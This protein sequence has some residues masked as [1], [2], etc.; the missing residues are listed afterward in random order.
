MLNKIL[1]Q[2][3]LVTESL[4]VASVAKTLKSLHKITDDRKMLSTLRDIQHKI[5]TTTVNKVKAVKLSKR[6][7]ELA[8]TILAGDDSET[9]VRDIEKELK[10]L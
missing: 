2:I 10:T 6:L 1:R 7:D 3:G 4:D 5:N 9:I 8:E